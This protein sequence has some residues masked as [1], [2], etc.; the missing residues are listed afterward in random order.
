MEALVSLSL[1]SVDMVCIG[2]KNSQTSPLNFWQPQIVMILASR[3]FAGSV[4]PALYSLRETL[5]RIRR[6]LRRLEKSNSSESLWY[7]IRKFLSKYKE[8]ATHSPSWSCP[9]LTRLG[10]TDRQ[11]CGYQIWSIET[12]KTWFYRYNVCTHFLG[13]LGSE[14]LSPYLLG[15]P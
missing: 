9:G 8:S 3:G 11:D 13:S 14:P 4:N 5:L 7:F 6:W 15:L 2:A 1:S 10:K 12:R